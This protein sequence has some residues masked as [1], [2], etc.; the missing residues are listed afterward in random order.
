MFDQLVTGLTSYQLI[1]DVL[2]CSP[3]M[4]ASAVLPYWFD[5]H[6]E[7]TTKQMC[8]K[9]GYLLLKAAALCFP[10]LLLCF[11]QWCRNVTQLCMRTVDASCLVTKSVEVSNSKCL[12]ACLSVVTLC[13]QFLYSCLW[14]HT[15]QCSSGVPS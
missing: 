14:V 4:C 15:V 8:L 3:M 9:V 12:L 5:T 10:S 7:Y 1:C 6:K 11:L 13:L 2:G